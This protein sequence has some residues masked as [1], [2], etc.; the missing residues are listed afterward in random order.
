MPN[1]GAE[2]LYLPV[3]HA[4]Y[5]GSPPEVET[6]VQTPLNEG[7]RNR[8]LARC[9]KED[10]RRLVSDSI[11]IS[12][13]L[14]KELYRAGEPMDAIYFPLNC[15]VSV[16]VG[17]GVDE[18]RVEMAT[19]GNEGAV[20]VYAVLNDARSI[21]TNIVQVGG[22]AL[23]IDVA[24]FKERLRHNPGLHDLM[25][26][27]MYALTHQIVQ[28]GAC[29]RLH[30]MEERCARWLLMMHDRT[31]NDKNSFPLTQEF[32]AEMLGVRRAT[33]NLAIGIL[34]NAGFIQYIRGQITV[35]DRAGLESASCP[36]YDLIRKEYQALPR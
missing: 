3:R 2:L 20:G 21:G 24:G 8:L 25:H 32:L 29:N 10:Y 36:C 1:D 33:V 11:V 23:R 28:A 27:Y 7:T 22:D 13:P 19:I 14:Y 15:V 12:L 5:A 26:Q 9:S 6:V 4:C 34:K 35:V 17:G 30:T 16:L 18:P 31:E